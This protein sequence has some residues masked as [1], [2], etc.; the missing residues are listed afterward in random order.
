VKVIDD[1]HSYITEHGDGKQWGRRDCYAEEHNIRG[2]RDVGEKG[3]YDLQTAFDLDPTRPYFLVYGIYS[4]GDSFGHDEGRIEFVGLYEDL[5]VAHENVRRI[6]QHNEM[7]NQLENRW[8]T[9]SK[10]MSKAEMTKLRKTFEPYS[11]QLV[12]EDGQEYKVHVPWH[13]Y[14][15]RLTEVE[16][17]P[18]LVC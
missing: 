13:G 16:V 2:V 5:E 17:Q 15:E 4:T 12:T 8:Y 1:S 6:Q 18:V 7:Y 10:Q 11:V 3:Y 9:S 14:F